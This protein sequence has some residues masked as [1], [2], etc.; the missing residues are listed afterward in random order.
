MMSL[1]PWQGLDT[2]G[3]DVTLLSGTGMPTIAALRDATSPMISSNL[4]LATECLR[5]VHLWP[6]NEAADVMQLGAGT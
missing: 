1:Q 5:R 4:C 2:N 6:P 3:Y